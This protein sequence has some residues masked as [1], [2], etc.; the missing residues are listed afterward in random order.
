MV[1]IYEFLP[2]VL[3][4]EEVLQ[5]LLNLPVYWDLPENQVIQ[6]KLEAAR[7]QGFSQAIAFIEQNP[8]QFFLGQASNRWR[9]DIGKPFDGDVFLR[10]LQ[11]GRGQQYAITN[12]PHFVSRGGHEWGYGGTGPRNLALDILSFFSPPDRDSLVLNHGAA[13]SKVSFDLQ[14]KFRD[15]VLAHMPRSGGFLPKAL[16]EAYVLAYGTTAQD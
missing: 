4:R 13:V 6:L 11:L 16:L 9:L 12:V 14:Y 2:S 5:E 8:E 15:S 7:K 10:R 1:E 3:V